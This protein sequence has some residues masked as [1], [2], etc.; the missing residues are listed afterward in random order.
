MKSDGIRWKMMT[1][2]M[3]VMVMV[4]VVVV[5][6][7][8]VVVMLMLMVIVGKTSAILYTQLPINRPMAA[9]C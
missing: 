2:M 6:V 5:V 8:F 7:V 4:V 1:M 9:L 3:V